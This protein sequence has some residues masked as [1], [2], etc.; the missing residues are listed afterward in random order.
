MPPGAGKSLLAKKLVRRL[1]ETHSEQ[2]V[3]ILNEDCYYRAR[4]ELDFEEREQINYDH[5]D[6]LEHDLL[7]QQLKSLCQRCCGRGA[8]I[9]LWSAQPKVRN[10][11]T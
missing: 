2:D 9:R 11:E 1:R 5:P 8:A 3:S 7:I 10:S 6:A 4:D